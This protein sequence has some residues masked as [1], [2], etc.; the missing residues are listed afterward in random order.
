MVINHNLA[1]MNTNRSLSINTDNKSKSMKRL[2]SGYRVNVAADDAAALS[3]SEKMRSQIRGLDR[4]SDNAN[5]GISFVQ[6]ADGALGEMNA[7]LERCKELV[8]QGANDT[9]TRSDRDAIQQ[10]LDSLTKEL[11]RISTSTN[12]NTID[13]FSADGYPPDY[14]SN[15]YEEP[16]PVSYAPP[17][18]VEWNFIDDDGNVVVSVSGT[19]AAGATRNLSGA[20]Q[21]LASD[22]VE[23]ANQ[24]VNRLSE[25]Y[26]NLFA[27]ASTDGIKVGLNIANIDG[28]GSVLASASLTPGGDADGAVLGYTMNVDLSDFNPENYDLTKLKTTIA[29]EMT[30]LV[31]FDTNTRNMF[32]QSG[33]AFPLWFIEGMAQTTSGDGGWLS[34]R[35][36]S[37]SSDADLRGYMSQMSSMP[38]GAGYLAT[39][40]LGAKAGGG[41]VDSASIASGLDKILTDV[42]GGSTLDQA[43]ADNTSFSGLND[44]SSQFTGGGADALQFTRDFLA[45]RGAGGSGSL[46]AGLNTPAGQLFDGVNNSASNYTVHTDNTLYNNIFGTPLSIPNAGTLGGPGGS[47]GGG[48]G[49]IY[50]GTT[51]KLQVGALSGQTVDL[52]RFD[53]SANAIL[54]NNMLSVFDNEIAGDSINIVDKALTRVS[55]VR[56]YYGALQNRLEHT[57]ANLDNTSENTQAAESK[58]R[59]ADMASEMV[60]FA[61]DNILEQAAQAML[62]QANSQ[63]ENIMKLFEGL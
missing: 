46:L 42:A 35:I 24:T 53:V 9:N 33:T 15:N 39:M 32:P 20:M 55:A 56:S 3:I 10:E 23:A 54:G 28:R 30:H 61:K 19:V 14:L 58:L 34:G 59:D 52:L 16:S 2:S 57:I 6:I 41:S 50:E 1:A 12:Y 29:H 44:F 60:A 31:M 11:D 27:A 40:Y 43:I 7:I 63:P 17:V 21:N 62:A 38:Y 45:A 36:N 37:S 25:L 26:P 22:V 48:G 51:L 5:D 47:T 8:V 13:V 49:I 4:A 18:E